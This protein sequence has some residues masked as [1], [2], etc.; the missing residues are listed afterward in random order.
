MRAGFQGWAGTLLALAGLL[1]G[2]LPARAQDVR[3]ADNTAV[4]PVDRKDQ[5]GW[6]KRHERF[7]ERAKQ[8]DVD[9]LFLGDSITHGWESNGKKVWEEHFAPLKAA[10]FGIGGDRTQHV[11][12]RI[13]EGKEL[14]GIDP[15]VAVL[16]I[17][18]N[19]AS[20]NTAKE[21]AEGVEAI[22]KELRRQKPKVKVLVL[23]VFPRGGK[24]REKE[25]TEVKA[26]DLHPKI[27]EINGL[28]AKLDDGKAVKYLDIGGK[29]LDKSGDLQKAVMYDFLHLTDNGYA[30][31]AEA[32]KP[33]VVNM[34]GD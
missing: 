3:K 5:G 21:I 18:T 12:W 19:N 8:G 6:Q 13:T 9:V 7:L 22:V 15:K 17:G 32:I 23:G 1:L 24:R 31:W 29:L 14:D 26:E 33:N 10:N 28:I 16:M 30:I 34:L 11:L 20:S 2:G 4:K 25:Q 27:K